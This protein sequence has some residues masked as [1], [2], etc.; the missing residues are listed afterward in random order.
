MPDTI[1]EEAAKCVLAPVEVVQISIPVPLGRGKGSLP[2][3]NERG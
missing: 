1:P 2:I 3:D